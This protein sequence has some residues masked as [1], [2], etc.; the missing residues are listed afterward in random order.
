MAEVT[1]F[2]SYGLSPCECAQKTAWLTNPQ[3]DFWQHHATSVYH[4]KKEKMS[5]TKRGTLMSVGGSRTVRAQKAREKMSLTSGP[6]QRDPV[7]S[8]TSRVQER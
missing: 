7:H 8:P 5:P 4:G 6:S 3:L 1:D 2:P